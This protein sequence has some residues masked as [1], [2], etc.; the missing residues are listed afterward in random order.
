[1][2][3]TN[4]IVIGSVCAFLGGVGIT[5]GPLLGISEFAGPWSFVMGFIFGVL[6]GAGVALLVFGLFEKRKNGEKGQRRK[7]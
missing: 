6:G 3:S 2:K 5:L 7:S 1:M 4:K